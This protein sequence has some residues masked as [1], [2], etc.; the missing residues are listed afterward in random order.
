MWYNLQGQRTRVEWAGHVWRAD[1]SVF[2]EALI[3]TI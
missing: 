3:Y 1:G 2:K